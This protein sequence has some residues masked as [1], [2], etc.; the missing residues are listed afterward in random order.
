MDHVEFIH[1]PSVAPWVVSTFYVTVFFPKS[2]F[3]FSDTKYLF[4]DQDS[5]SVL[6]TFQVWSRG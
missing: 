3:L 2:V 6:G 4:L 1:R 5:K